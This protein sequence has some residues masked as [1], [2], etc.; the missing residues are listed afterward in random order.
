M[1][2]Y[3]WLLR[4]QLPYSSWYIDCIIKGQTMLETVVA[5]IRVGWG[6]GGSG[7]EGG[8]GGVRLGSWAGL[9]LGLGLGWGL[10][11]GV[12]RLRERLWLC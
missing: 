10:G 9:G 5:G 3:V 6:R 2:D 7:F 1:Y 12:A 11:S 4:T 8:W